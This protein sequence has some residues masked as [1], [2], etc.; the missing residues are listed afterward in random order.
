[1]WHA[2]NESGRAGLEFAIGL[3]RIL[4]IR[5]GHFGAEQPHNGRNSDPCVLLLASLEAPSLLRRNVNASG[6]MLSCHFEVAGTFQ[7]IPWCLG[8]H[9]DS[10]GWH[11]QATLS[12]REITASGG[13]GLEQ[14]ARIPI[15]PFIARYTWPVGCF[16]MDVLDCASANGKAQGDLIW[17][18]CRRIL[19]LL[20]VITYCIAHGMTYGAVAR[21][22][23]FNTPT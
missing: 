22:R 5:A 14:T 13:N 19:G 3:L 7:R 9:H 16:T 12:A 6:L 8:F 2:L 21:R 18:R 11:H 20:H 15:A 4:A 10:A 17:C 1:M 23:I